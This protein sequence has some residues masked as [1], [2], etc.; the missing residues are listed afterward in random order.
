MPS[1]QMIAQA[2]SGVKIAL[3]TP[4]GDY[5]FIS[6]AHSD[7]SS[8]AKSKGAK[9]IASPETAALLGYEGD[10]HAADGLELR[11]AGH[12]LGSCAALLD[13]SDGKL[14]YTGDMKTEDSITT[15]GADIVACDT[16]VI[17]GT[18]ANPQVKFEP[19]EEVYGQIASWTEKSL[20]SGIVV[21]GG[22]ALG[23]SQELIKVLNRKCGITPVVP[24]SV[25]NFC[26]VYN[27]FGAGLECV[28]STSARGQEMM[29][30]D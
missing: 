29:E 2:K 5:C 3:D 27:R 6:H 13:T 4:G 24:Q 25:M 11:N 1:G 21:L 30:G 7:H 20:K 26:D 16:L 22:Y 23:K 14:L 9:I 10:L 15:K 28:L 18:F 19:R 12:I 8:A 17:E